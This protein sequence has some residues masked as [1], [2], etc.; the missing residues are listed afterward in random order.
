MKRTLLCIAAGLL[1]GTGT[2]Q[3]EDT[4]VPRFDL[5]K[6][7][8]E[9]N[10]ILKPDEVARI[11]AKHT[12]PQKD[13]GTLQ[14]AM[15]D[16]EKAYRRK[17]YTLVTVLLPEQELER[18]TVIITVLEPTVKEI[19]VSGNKHFS[20]ESILS[21]LPTLRVG[22]PPKISAISENL[23]AVNEN[24]GRKITLQF[25][26]PDKP[27]ELQAVVQVKDQKTWKIAVTGDNTGNRQSG[28]YRTGLLLQHYNL[29]NLDHIAALQYS[30]SPDHADKVTIISGSYRL[31]LYNWGDTIDLFGGYSDV[32]NGTSQISGTSLS[33]SGKG[34]LSGI[35][36]NLNLPRFGAYEQKLSMGLDYREYD[37]TLMLLGVDIA[38]DVVAHPFSITYG[39]SWSS[40]LATADGY[41]GV[42]HNQPWGGRGQ[43]KDF[44]Q[45]RSGAKADYWIFRY[46]FNKMVRPGKD[47][48]FR[49]AGNGQYTPDRLIPGEQFGLGGGSSVR[50]YAEREEAYDAGFNGTFELYTPDLAPMLT[51]PKTQLRLVGFYDGGVGYNLRPQLQSSETTGHYLTSVG[52]GVRLGVGDFL[53]FS[54]DW[55]HALNSSL[56]VQEPTRRGD[57]RIHFKASIS[58]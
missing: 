43:Q 39:G 32:D 48:I 4:V 10:T 2:A 29:W 1:I 36:Y 56:A 25:K 47:W 28:Y 31:P 20:R 19:L 23:R 44:E 41:L 46:G 3:A 55:G 7:L 21:V 26:T 27:E 15:D 13:F 12:G 16:I 9:G 51:V 35:R 50:G 30:T 49:V 57:N 11:L 8:L 14:E 5:H 18:G 24:P 53:S 45:V 58:Y 38:R 37:N 22:Q 6:I 33:I 17:G 52:A 42:L 40:D 54:L 34:I